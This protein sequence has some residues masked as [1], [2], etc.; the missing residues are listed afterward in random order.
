MVTAEVVELLA[1]VV[2]V[3]GALDSDIDFRTLVDAVAVVEKL[4]KILRHVIHLRFF[5]N[6]VILNFLPKI[7]LTSIPW[8]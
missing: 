4:I 5:I 6:R 2:L 7:L 3:V 8:K 1:V